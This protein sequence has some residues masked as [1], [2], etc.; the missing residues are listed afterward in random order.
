MASVA[1]SLSRIK[2]DLEPLLPQARIRCV[3]RS[4]ARQ[5]RGRQFEPVMTLHLFILQV[6]NFNTAMTRRGAT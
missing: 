5:W 3:C 6:L 2:L 4:L 1:S